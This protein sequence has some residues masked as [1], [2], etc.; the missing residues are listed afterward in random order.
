M[1]RSTTLAGAGAI[2]FGVLT[3]VGFLGGTPGGN[4]DEATGVVAH[5]AV[6]HSKQYPSQITITVVKKATSTSQH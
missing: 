3:V 5:N 1:K 2:A 6:H 4:Y